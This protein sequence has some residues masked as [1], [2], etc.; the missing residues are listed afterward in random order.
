MK[1]ETPL[2][3]IFGLPTWALV[4]GTWSSLSQLADRLPEGYNIS[5][6]L[7]LSLTLGNIFPIAIGC[8]LEK[9]FSSSLLENLIYWILAIGA[10]TGI[11][12][13][14]FY[15]YSVSIGGSDIS[16]PLCILFFIVGGCSSS[17]NV[18]HFTYVSTFS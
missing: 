17:S 4:D 15:D 5:A 10:F 12:M 1:P 9:F 13:G 2:F 18:T 11:L 7:I 8:A 16:L 14:V 6:Y 3:V